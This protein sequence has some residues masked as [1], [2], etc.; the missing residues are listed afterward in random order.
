MSYQQI[1]I[2]GY[3]YKGIDRTEDYKQ[4]FPIKP[5]GLTIL[6][7]G[8]N[9]GFYG[10]KAISE[11][12]NYVLGIDNNDPFLNIGR[13][14]AQ[15]L[16]YDNIDFMRLNVLKENIPNRK[17]DVVLCLNLVHHFNNINQVNYLFDQLWSRCEKTIIF[18]VLNCKA[19]WEIIANKIGNRK[20]HLSVDFFKKKYPNSLIELVSSK[21][22]ENRS[23]IR[24][25]K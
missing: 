21:V 16:G 19:E 8:C 1:D 23:I 20:I 17:F 6:D 7:I 22:T 10:L 5:E 13:N 24:V 3:Y 9:N 15:S 2:D 4:I 18:E 25:I 12:A 14:A 11:G